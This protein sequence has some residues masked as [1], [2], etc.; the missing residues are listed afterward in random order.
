MGK[1]GFREF[2]K[3]QKSDHSEYNYDNVKEG[4]LMLTKLLRH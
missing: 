4:Q 1:S 2:L 3:G